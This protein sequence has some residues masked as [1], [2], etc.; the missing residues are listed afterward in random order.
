MP[1]LKTKKGVSKR[2]RLTKK[3]KVKRGHGGRGHLL[4]KKSRQKKRKLKK[5]AFLEGKSRAI[6]SKFIPYS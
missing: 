3:G 5:P 1:K 6:I 4:G 2:F